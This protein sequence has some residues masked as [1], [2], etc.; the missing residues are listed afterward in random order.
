MKNQ[1]FVQSLKCALEGLKTENYVIINL[2]TTINIPKNLLKE[3]EFVVIS[4]KRISE[5]VEY[6]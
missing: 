1:N 6:F 4:K 3:K 5:I 2:M